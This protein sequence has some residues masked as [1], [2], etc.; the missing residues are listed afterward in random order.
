MELVRWIRAWSYVERVKKWLG[1]GF[2]LFGLFLIGGMVHQDFVRQSVGDGFRCGHI[3]IP[4]R[5]LFNLLFRFAGM[6]GQNAIQTFLEIEHEADG[7]LYVGSGAL[8]SAGDLVDHDMGIGEAKTFSGS[9]GGQQDGAHGGGNAQA[10]GVHIAG[11]KLHR[12]I[13]GQSRR[14]RAAGGININVN[15]LFRVCHLEEQQLGN[16]GVGYVV[17]N[18]GADE[19]DAVLEEP[20]IN[21]KSA[22]PA[23]VLFHDHGDVVG[24]YA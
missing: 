7:A 3:I 5:I 2:R 4:V 17:I 21:V 24:F 20:G 18:A 13:N 11:N 6:F 1:S 15:V 10:V 14:D 23:S 22:F 8:R 19:D 9:A 16:D 12:I